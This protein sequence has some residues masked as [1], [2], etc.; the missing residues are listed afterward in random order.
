[1][2]H[3]IGSVTGLSVLA[4]GAHP[5]DVE[6]GCGGTLA[7]L[8]REGAHVRVV[9]LSQGR[10]GSLSDADRADE[11]RTAL[12]T[13]GISDITVHD[14]PD[15]RLSEHL[16]ELIEVLHKHVEEVRPRRAYTMFQYDRHQDHRAVYEASA[17][18][19]R[20]VAQLLGYETP[21]SYPNFLPTV[22][23]PIADDLETKV[24]ALKSHFSQGSRLYMQEEKIR[25][26]AN[27]RGAQV[28]L[29]PC[30]GFIPYKM[31]L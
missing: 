8:T 24:R 21:S 1:V 2:D 31:V 16:N 19:C 11:T 22:F 29:G 17:V 13:L 3:E 6:L 14:F 10:R 7:K 15:T 25:S 4:I 26:A 28:D 18:A 27:F 9:I 12:G 5:D 30:E 23:E 20:G